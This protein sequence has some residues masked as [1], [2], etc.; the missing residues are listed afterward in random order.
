MDKQKLKNLINAYMAA[1]ATAEQEKELRA[2]VLKADLTALPPALAADVR[3]VRM[4]M[5]DPAPIPQ[6]SNFTDVL[7]SQLDAL[8]KK[9]TKGVEHS[10]R[11]LKWLW[12]GVSVAAVAAVVAMVLLS[13]PSITDSGVSEAPR[14]VKTASPMAQHKNAEG[15]LTPAQASTESSTAKTV[16]RQLASASSGLKRQ[17][18]SESG[19]RV[20]KAGT[21]VIDEYYDDKSDEFGTKS[22]EEVDAPVVIRTA[23]GELLA[24]NSMEHSPEAIEMIGEALKLLSSSGR[25]IERGLSHSQRMITRSAE[26]MEKEN[27]Y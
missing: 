26:E 1:S 12:R 25:E 19:H 27:N 16:D 23:G 20:K 7:L 5:Q 14:S 18:A 15:I 2:L 4:L 10:A 24:Y 22:A 8:Q 6:P 21:L 9:E 13:G 3:L 11:R 17:R